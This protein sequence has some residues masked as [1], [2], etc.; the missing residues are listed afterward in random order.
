MKAHHS[1]VNEKKSFE[2]KVR[3]CLLFP[4]SIRP[5]ARAMHYNSAFVA[6]IESP[7]N[8]RMTRHTHVTSKS[9]IRDN[10]NNQ[11]WSVG[12]ALRL[13][14]SRISAAMPLLVIFARMW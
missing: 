3:M 8:T 12:N 11:D 7:V 1:V 10:I 4:V 6:P 5:Q 2:I 9:S 13:L 14:C